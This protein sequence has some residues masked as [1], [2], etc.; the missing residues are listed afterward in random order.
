M[1]QM[2]LN[3]VSTFKGDGITQATRQLGAFGKQTSSLGSVLGK[4][5][6]GLA[7]LGLAA[8]SIQFGRESN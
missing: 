7:S 1:S 8:K 6:T 2:F 4:V 3:V 5:A